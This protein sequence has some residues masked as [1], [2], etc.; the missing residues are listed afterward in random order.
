MSRA[1]SRSGRPPLAGGSAAAGG[2]SFGKFSSKRAI[3]R[4]KLLADL[5]GGRATL[6]AS[7]AAAPS[8]PTATTID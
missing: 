1:K 2:K 7:R 3:E 5:S 8:T 4:A 6:S